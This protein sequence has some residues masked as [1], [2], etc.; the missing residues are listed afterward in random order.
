MNLKPAGRRDRR[1]IAAV[2]LAVSASLLFMF[3]IGIIEFSRL[4]MISQLLTNS[5]REASRVAAIQN[6]KTSDVQSRMN[7]VLGGTGVAVTSLTAVDSDPGTD[8]AFIMP[9]G[10]ATAPGDTAITVTVR[11]PYSQVSL[12]AP[13]FLTSAK[14]VGTATMNSERP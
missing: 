6:S 9:S 10:W 12:T 3:V 14:V 11:I 4:G 8:G 5:A 1:G 13:Y 7:A 2:E